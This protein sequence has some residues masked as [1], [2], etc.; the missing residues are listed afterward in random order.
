MARPKYET[1][2]DRENEQKIVETVCRVW[3]CKAEKLPISYNFD[4]ALSK[5]GKIKAFLE[6]KHRK[7]RSNE[8]PTYMLSMNK[9]IAGKRYEKHTDITPILVVRFVDGLYYCKL[10]DHQ[11]MTG[12]RFAL[13]G[14][15]VN[16]RDEQDAEPCL[17]IPMEHFKKL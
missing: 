3:Q 5:D 7:T 4:Y 6:I 11:E 13:R 14:R 10:V 17:M 2:A 15:T 16:S 8:Y 12:A 1:D 9:Y